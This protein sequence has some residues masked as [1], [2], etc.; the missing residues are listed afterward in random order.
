MPTPPLGLTGDWNHVDSGDWAEVL[1]GFPLFSGNRQAP[2]AQPRPRGDVRG[3]WPRR[4]R[5]PE[6]RG[7]R[8]A[9]RRS[10]R[11]GEGAWKACRTGAPHRRLLRRAGAPR[12]RP[13]IRDG[14]R[15]RR[16]ARDEAAAAYVSPHRAARAVDLARDA[17]HPRLATPTARSPGRL[18]H[19]GSPLPRQKEMP[20]GSRILRTQRLEEGCSRWHSP[21]RTT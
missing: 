1:A 7:R 14:R 11:V 8:L 16:A 15:D 12:R 5:P 6:G 4:G 3:V 10:Q 19:R 21:R 17:E 18:S 20:G 13:E 2:P 9:L